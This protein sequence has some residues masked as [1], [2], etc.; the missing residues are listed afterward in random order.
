MMRWHYKPGCRKDELIAERTRTRTETD[1][2]GVT[3]TTRCLANCY[4]GSVF[5]GVLWSVWERTIEKNGEQVKTP[6]RWIGCDLLHYENGFGWG[7]K[8]LDEASHPDY[9]SCPLNYLDLVPIEVYGGHQEW[10]D[11]VRRFHARR[12]KG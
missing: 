4:L 10:R 7:Y 11:G 8:F 12:S 1:D 6:Q 9:F 3:S 5:T 2:H